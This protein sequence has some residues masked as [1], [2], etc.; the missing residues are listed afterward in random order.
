[1]THYAVVLSFWLTAIDN[2]D[3]NVHLVL[4]AIVVFLGLTL[5]F[6]PWLIANHR[7]HHNQV[8]IFLVNLFFGWTAIGWLVSLIWAFTSPAPNQVVVVQQINPPPENGGR[9]R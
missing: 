8:P 2:P 7:H 9:G 6:M 1:M 3:A 5:Y 4:I